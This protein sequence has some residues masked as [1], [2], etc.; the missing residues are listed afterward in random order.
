MA[1]FRV[2]E[3]KLAIVTGASRSFGAVL[4]EHF[5]SRGAN[6]VINYATEGSTSKAEALAKD[7]ESKYNVKALPVRADLSKPEAPQQL[8]D[9][10][11]AHFIDANG[12]FQIDIIVNNAA[13]VNAQGIDQL[14]L[15]LFDET[16]NLNCK[17][18][19]LLVKAAFPYLPTDRSGRIVNISSA[20][21]TWGVWWQ[22][23][24]AGTKGAIEAMTRVWARELAERATVNAVAPGPMDTGLYSGLPDEPREALRP[25]NNLTPLA[26][27]RP[28]VDSQE[29]LDLAA[30]IG[31]RPGYLEEVA[32]VVG[33]VCLPESGWMTGNLVGASGGGAFV[34]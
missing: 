9:A 16:F 4:A 8:V 13:T 7:F 19:A 22:T 18:P 11:K 20:T 24:Y 15:D 21:T 33:V 6:V 5:A 3:G 34:R 31:G 1:P 26:K 17:A 32:G 29:V 28:G 10:A 2:F 23:S 14:D 25:L 12:R 30:S 27:A